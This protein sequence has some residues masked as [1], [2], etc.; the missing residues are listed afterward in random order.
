MVINASFVRKV[1]G[2]SV[3]TAASDYLTRNGSQSGP[4]GTFVKQVTGSSLTKA[5]LARYSAN[6]GTRNS[7]TAAFV[8]KVSGTSLTSA[9]LAYYRNKKGGYTLQRKRG[10]TSQKDPVAVRLNRM[11]TTE[12]GIGKYVSYVYSGKSRVVRATDNLIGVRLESG[13]KGWVDVKGRFLSLENAR[14][15]LRSLD[16][17]TVG[18]GSD[19]SLEAVWDE[20][21]PT[22]KAKIAEILMD[23]DWDAFWK[24]Y[25]PKDDGRGDYDTQAEM[26]Q[27]IV[28]KISKAV[29]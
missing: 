5:S 7:P 14:Y 21:S 28:E 19:L 23:V 18:Y 22:Q 15:T 8:K 27:D 25:Y 29:N 17:T 3:K 24:E 9:S 26:Y 11:L 12:S 20:A 4:V 13:V 16:Y 2:K 6:K 10:K 1:S